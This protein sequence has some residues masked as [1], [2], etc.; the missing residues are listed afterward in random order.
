MPKNKTPDLFGEETGA[1]NKNHR[2]EYP[3]TFQHNPQRSIRRRIKRLL[4][5]LGTLGFLQMMCVE[6]IVRRWFSHD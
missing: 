6:L 3:N 2:Y 4:V 1:T 5:Q